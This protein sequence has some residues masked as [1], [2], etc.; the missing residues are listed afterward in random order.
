MTSRGD[1]EDLSGIALKIYLYLLESDGAGPREIARELGINPSLAYYH[2]KKFEELGIV[3]KDL[4]RGVYKVK[5]RIRVRGYLYLG[6]K[7]V[8][9]LLIYGAFFAGLLIPETVSIA[10]GML[11]A[12]PE[13]ILAMLTSAAAAAIFMIEGIMALRNLR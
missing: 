10:I 13:L 9:R 5:R 4:S 8:P 12:T 1:N 6:G 7:L 11:E 2:L 3:E